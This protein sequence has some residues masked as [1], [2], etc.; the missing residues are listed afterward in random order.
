MKFEKHRIQYIQPSV[1]GIWTQQ[2]LVPSNPS[3]LSLQANFLAKGKSAQMQ[4]SY[5]KCNISHSCIIKDT[6]AD[7]LGKIGI[8]SSSPLCSYE[9]LP[10][11]SL[12]ISFSVI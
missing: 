5:I 6:D 8:S 7:V 2:K 4:E 11:D 3:H 9:F 1:T 12:P 10:I